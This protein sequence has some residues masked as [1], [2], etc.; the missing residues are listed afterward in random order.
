[1]TTEK[2]IILPDNAIKENPSV[3]TLTNIET[4]VYA[5]AHVTLAQDLFSLVPAL[6]EASSMTEAEN[7]VSNTFQKL[8]TS[9]LSPPTCT[10]QQYFATASS[11]QFYA[12]ALEALVQIKMGILKTPLDTF[13]YVDRKI[14]KALDITEKSLVNCVTNNITTSNITLGISSQNT[15]GDSKTAQQY[16]TVSIMPIKQGIQALRACQSYERGLA[17]FSLF[18]KSSSQIGDNDT[19]LQI[20]KNELHAALAGQDEKSFEIGRYITGLSHLVFI[21]GFL[22]EYNKKEETQQRILECRNHA[23]P[24][25]LVYFYHYES[26]QAASYLIKNRWEQAVE[27]HKKAL[28]TAEENH[29]LIPSCDTLTLCALG[30]CYKTHFIYDSIHT[31]PKGDYFTQQHNLL[32]DTSLRFYTEAWERLNKKLDETS[33]QT[34]CDTH[35][36]LTFLLYREIDTLADEYSKQRNFGKAIETRKLISTLLEKVQNLAEPNVLDTKPVSKLQSTNQKKITIA[37]NIITSDTKRK[38]TLEKQKQRDEEERKLADQAYEER[39]ASL[40][41]QFDDEEKKEQDNA[42]NAMRQARQRSNAFVQ[43]MRDKGPVASL[44]QSLPQVSIAAASSE[45]LQ[46]PLPTPL[47]EYLISFRDGLTLL[48]DRA[49][50]NA[51]IAAFSQ[52][53]RKTTRETSTEDIAKAHWG[54][55]E[56]WA[57][58]AR[59]ALKEQKI[60]EAL[61][62]FETTLHS[63]GQGIH[64][65][66]QS[67]KEATEIREAL[68]FMLEDTNKILEHTR[69]AQEKKQQR[70][71]AQYK[72]LFDSRDQVIFDMGLRRFAN[73]PRAKALVAKAKANTLSQEETD[74]IYTVG[75]QIWR[76]NPNPKNIQANER[77]AFGQKLEE[78]Q[79]VNEHIAKVQ[80]GFRYVTTAAQTLHIE[81][82]ELQR[83][84]GKAWVEP[85][86]SAS[87]PPLPKKVEEASPTPIPSSSS[88]NTTPSFVARVRDES[89]ARKMSP[90]A[91]LSSS[92]GNTKLSFA[93][94]VKGEKVQKAAPS[95]SET[96][97]KPVTE[98]EISSSPRV[99]DDS[100]IPVIIHGRGTAQSFLL[101][102]ISRQK[103]SFVPRG[104]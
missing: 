91:A 62:Y 101:N 21:Y 5:I 12:T 42:R 80:E 97:N 58:K 31:P 61:E 64:T 55:A 74:R 17:Y 86:S 10:P 6:R 18:V 37:E 41:K 84:T 90:I 35:S 63:I 44:H 60:T 30:E 100:N 54:L 26:F 78:T 102:T 87:F 20:A 89:N 93:E 33:R 104:K 11:Q 69:Q 66:S 103:D 77:K 82:E 16:N 13:F 24:E 23:K 25:E 1:M 29:T 94:R 40:L 95:V 57:Q 96:P 34:Y 45:P 65:L 14:T 49:Q 9:H 15:L 83:Y 59:K 51:A 43:K 92:S 50:S 3:E 46:I 2:N 36:N 98:P 72:D 47:P 81:P 70:Q 68:D 4:S 32:L 39:F 52:S 79:A 28:R 56:S 19:N 67:G 7:I 88:A 48:Q 76:T 53:L 8:N 73:D 99:V 75:L 38:A 22:G 27:W 85:L 71:E